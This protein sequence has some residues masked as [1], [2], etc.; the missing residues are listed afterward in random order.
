MVY[1]WLNNV[2][3]HFYPAACLICGQTATGQAL[4]ICK[5]CHSALPWQSH[6]CPHCAATLPT[7]AL[8]CGACLRRPPP[9]QAATSALHYHFPVDRLLQ[10]FKFQ[11]QLAVGRLL[12]ELLA[13]RLAARAEPLPACIVPVPLHPARLAERGFN[14]AAELARPLARRL[15]LT[16]T[17]DLCHRVRDT[18]H[19]AQLAAAERRRN[20]R[21]AFDVRGR[22]PTHL[23]ILDDII[24][25]GST[26]TELARALRRAGAE[27]IEVW[28]VA[29]A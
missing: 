5:P 2:H 13:G 29:R 26:V 22:V 18:A 1:T 24:T 14:Q 9:F 4:D 11:G 12:G 7:G 27:C 23:A 16:I 21:D 20:L 25:T 10:Q 6:A 3:R 15:N 28:S 19:Q 17:H 8:H